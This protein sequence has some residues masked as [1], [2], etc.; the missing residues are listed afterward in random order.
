M[1]IQGELYYSCN[2]DYICYPKAK[3]WQVLQH[4]IWKRKRSKYRHGDRKQNKLFFACPIS[5]RGTRED[6]SWEYSAWAEMH[7][8][9][10][11]RYCAHKCPTLVSIMHIPSFMLLLSFHLG[12]EEIEKKK[13]MLCILENT[14]LFLCSLKRFRPSNGRKDKLWSKGFYCMIWTV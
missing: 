12:K 5:G 11:E 13:N 6:N 14:V 9:V 4:S 1:T 8:T 3:H 10:V 7:C 2:S